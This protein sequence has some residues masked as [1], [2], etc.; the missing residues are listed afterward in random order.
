MLIVFP[1]PGVEYYR[2]DADRSIKRDWITTERLVDSLLERRILP[3]ITLFHWDTPQALQ[4]LCGG[5]AGRDMANY[6]ADYAGIVVKALGDRA[7]HWIT[8]NEP[9]EHAAFGHLLGTHARAATI[10]SRISVWPIINCWGTDLPLNNSA[11]SPDSRFRFAL[12][13]TPHYRPPAPVRG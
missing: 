11:T 7:K 2:K 6:F 8:L 4:D 10:P 9:W 1:L 5:F 12:S 13:L 3:F